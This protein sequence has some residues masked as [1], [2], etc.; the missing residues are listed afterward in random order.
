MRVAVAMH[1]VWVMSNPIY[2]SAF[3]RATR[4]HPCERRPATTDGNT[5]V[6]GLRFLFVPRPAALVLLPLFNRH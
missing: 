3:Y 6:A 1:S 4:N 5:A 2:G